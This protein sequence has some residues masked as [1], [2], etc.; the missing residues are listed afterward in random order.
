MSE[1]YQDDELVN[2]IPCEFCNRLIHCD[3]YIDHSNS[4]NL[5]ILNSNRIITSISNRIN[6]INLLNR[7]IDYN[8]EEDIDNE[9]VDEGNNEL[10]DEGNN[11][12][13]DEGNNE[14]VDDNLQEI[15]NI[16]EINQDHNLDEEYFNDLLRENLNEI[17]DIFSN[18]NHIQ[19]I[20][21]YI[22]SSNNLP[23][24]SQLQLLLNQL[25]INNLNID[26]TNIS[27]TLSSFFNV[28]LPEI[29]K[30]DITKIIQP[31]TKKINDGDDCPICF[32]SLN[33]LKGDNKPVEIQCNH[34]FC[35]NCIKKWFKK[36]SKCPLC[37]KNYNEDDDNDDDDNMP[38]LVADFSSDDDIPDLYE[39]ISR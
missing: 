21:N 8:V 31:L 6:N 25:N 34:V 4:C 10:V 15:G 38:D 37:K 22:Y 16:D 23:R 36:E 27:S 39:D 28:D 30:V 29:I 17:R 14:L 13:V 35:Y 19:L 11:E 7:N 3:N 2:L 32:E 24:N 12:L 1:N 26:S 9:L 20:R 18:D 33:S 5:L